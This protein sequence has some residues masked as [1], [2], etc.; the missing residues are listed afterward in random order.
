M[1][2]IERYTWWSLE[3]YLKRCLVV[4]REVPGEVTWGD[5]SVFTACSGYC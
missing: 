1:V 5:L 4:A 3:R 2:A